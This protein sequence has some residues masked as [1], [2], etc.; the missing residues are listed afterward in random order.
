MQSRRDG[1]GGLLLSG[2]DGKKR[3]D[4]VIEKLCPLS[5]KHGAGISRN[6]AD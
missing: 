6:W 2:G 1:C 3:V 5:V 4:G